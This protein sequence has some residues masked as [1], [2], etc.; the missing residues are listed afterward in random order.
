MLWFV[1]QTWE[2]LHKSFTIFS[3]WKKHSHLKSLDWEICPCLTKDQWVEQETPLCNHTS[4]L[5]FSVYGNLIQT[6]LDFHS[7]MLDHPPFAM[8]FYI[9]LK[10]L[11]RPLPYYTVKYHGNYVL[12]SMSN[13]VTVQLISAR[14][15]CF[16]F[17]LAALECTQ[18]NITLPNWYYFSKA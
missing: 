14:Y 2:V 18:E 15:K 4:V 13:K 1:R 5:K 3:T 11:S 7:F 17:G 12:T 6:L 16:C 10:F 8:T 9:H